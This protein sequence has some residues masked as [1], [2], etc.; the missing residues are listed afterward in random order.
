M[1]DPVLIPVVS[2]DPLNELGA[3]LEYRTRSN[4]RVPPSVAPKQI[5][6]QTKAQNTIPKQ[7]HRH[8][9][10]EKNAPK[11]MKIQKKFTYI[12]KSIINI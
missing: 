10:G 7:K 11:L 8:F 1:A 3:I 4:F 5:S 12:G 2:D 9:Q 6:R